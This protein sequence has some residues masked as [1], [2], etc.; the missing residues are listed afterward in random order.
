[1][2][3]TSVH[4]RTPLTYIYADFKNE[5]YFIGVAVLYLA[6]YFIGKKTNE[7]RANKW[8]VSSSQACAAPRY[9]CLITVHGLV[10]GSAHICLF[11]KHSSRDQQMRRASCQVSPS[12]SSQVPN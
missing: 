2:A 4:T 9:V 1:M 7:R 6:L 11:T 3:W 8:Y 10:L 5:M 12:D